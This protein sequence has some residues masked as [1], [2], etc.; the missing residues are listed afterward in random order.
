MKIFD[1]IHGVNNVV[2]SKP[3]IKRVLGSLDRR[4]NISVNA[5]QP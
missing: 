3:Q 2:I 1:C 4:A 5:A